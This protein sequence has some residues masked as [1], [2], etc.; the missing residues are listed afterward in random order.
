MQINLSMGKIRSASH[1][2][3]PDVVSVVPDPILPVK[4]KH[5]HQRGVSGGKSLQM[6]SH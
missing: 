5:S 4:C 3:N 2:Y 6:L 1:L